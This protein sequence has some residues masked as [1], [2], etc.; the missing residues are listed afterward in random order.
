LTYDNE[1]QGYA[2]R[3][4]AQKFNVLTGI[5]HFYPNWCD[6]YAIADYTGQSP[7]NIARTLSHWFKCRYKYVSRKR[8]KNFS[9]GIK[10]VYRLRKPGM[11][12]I[13]Y[14]RNRILRG[15]DLNR[16]KRFPV[17]VNTYVILNKKGIDM[18]MTQED[19]PDFKEILNK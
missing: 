15:Y 9:H 5:Y 12:A 16:N 17:K 18:S 11:K 2:H 4:N 8:V 13:I 1:P 10:Y 7:N 19:L 6:V 3:Y 14:F